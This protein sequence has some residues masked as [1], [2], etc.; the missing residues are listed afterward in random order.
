MPQNLFLQWTS[1]GILGCNLAKAKFIHFITCH[2][3]AHAKTG[4]VDATDQKLS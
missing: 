4:A 1:L 2:C 3:A